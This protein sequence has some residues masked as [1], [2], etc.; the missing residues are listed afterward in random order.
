MCFFAP[1]R[2]LGNFLEIEIIHSCA[3]ET[4]KMSCSKSDI[5]YVASEGH[6]I[7]HYIQDHGIPNM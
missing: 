7:C 2:I 4:L 6:I 3:N 1:F 5:I